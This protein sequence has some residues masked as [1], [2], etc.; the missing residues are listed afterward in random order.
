MSNAVKPSKPHI[1]PAT[2]EDCLYLA[3]NLRKEDLEELSHG[4]GLPPDVSVLIGFRTDR[5][6]YAV[7]HQDRVVAV[8]G[9]GGTPGVIG[10]PWMLA[11]D[12]LRDIRKS[13]LRGCLEFIS[14]ILTRYPHLENYVWS[15]NEGHLQWL[16]W[17]GFKFDSPAPWGIHDEPFQRFYMKA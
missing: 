1:R 2:R 10:Y 15:K 17:L 6:T 9:V 11:T 13:F 5:E 3:E 4:L 14:D 7:V 8:I 12:E 16:R